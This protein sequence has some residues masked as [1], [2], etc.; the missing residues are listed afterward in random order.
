MHFARIWAGNREA[1]EEI[2]NAVE[3]RCKEFF[4]A[5]TIQRRKLIA[6]MDPSL[7]DRLWLWAYSGVRN[8][9]QVSDILHVLVASAGQQPSLERLFELLRRLLVISSSPFG[10][11]MAL[12]PALN[13]LLSSNFEELRLHLSLKK[14]EIFAKKA[15]H[16]SELCGHRGGG[17]SAASVQLCAFGALLAGQ[18]R[19]AER[20]S[21]Q[22]VDE[23]LKQLLS[24]FRPDL[25]YRPWLYRVALLS[26]I[27]WNLRPQKARDALLRAPTPVSCTPEELRQLK[28]LQTLAKEK[29]ME[30]AK[31]AGRPW[32]DERGHSDSERPVATPTRTQGSSPG[33]QEAQEAP[34]RPSLA[35]KAALPQGVP[36]IQLLDVQ[37]SAGEAKVQGQIR[38][39]NRHRTGTSFHITLHDSSGEI[40]VKFWQEAASK[41]M[42]DSRLQEGNVVLL[43]GFS[44]TELKGASLEFAPAGRKHCLSFSVASSVEIQL[45]KDMPET[46]VSE[47]RRLPLNARL[48]LRARV[49]SVESLNVAQPGM[50][51]QC[52]RKIHLQELEREEG[53]G[54]TLTLWNQMARDYGEKQLPPGQRI[55]VRNA[56]VTEYLRSKELT[57]CSEIALI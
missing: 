52:M 45:L 54:I 35:P 9:D 22:D 32:A 33:S 13:H 7:G 20:L 44:F 8:V 31:A 29:A 19:F 53:P 30:Q 39:R 12:A 27:L 23:L 47:A 40:D 41:F 25:P 3:A 56:K 11:V 10:S 43:K 14:L 21:G 51:W 36:S 2:A 1:A 16:F 50:R 34:R 49:Q 15:F 24:G 42:E 38:R 26:G 57:G 17:M 48:S 5:D 28:A 6:S 46:T 37:G 18:L 55:F 4:H